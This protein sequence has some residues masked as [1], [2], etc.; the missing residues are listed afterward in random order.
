MRKIRTIIAGL[1]IALILTGCG[2]NITEKSKEQT[3]TEIETENQEKK[4]SE[5]LESGED[6]I[7]EVETEKI[8]E[9]KESSKKD[10]YIKKLDDIEAGLGDLNALSATGIT[11]D[12]IEA[13]SK[14]YSRWDDA[15]NEIYSYLKVQLSSSEMEAL[16][17]KQIEWIEYRDLTAKNESLMFEG[18]TMERVQYPET[19]ARLTKER[20]YELVRTYIQ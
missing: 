5:I 20:C 14:K 19:L 13:A 17:E 9:E 18:G 7:E 6:Y 15:L 10:E 8:P 12:M 16:T 3:K 11:S 4:D 1:G 2:N